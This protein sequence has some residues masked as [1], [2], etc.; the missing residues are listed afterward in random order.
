M[1][2]APFRVFKSWESDRS[3]ARNHEPGGILCPNPGSSPPLTYS[4]RSIGVYQSKK[5]KSSRARVAQSED[6]SAFL[7]CRKNERSF[8]LHSDQ[9][10]IRPQSGK[11]V[12]TPLV[13]RAMRPRRERLKNLERA[14]TASMKSAAKRA[15][16]IPV[17]NDDWELLPCKRGIAGIPHGFRFEAEEAPQT[18]IHSVLE[19]IAALCGNMAV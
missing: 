11:E 15:P 12:L 4:Q 6:Y 2:G 19:P 3:H 16:H 13:G 8:L 14:R 10:T 5:D 17:A 1:Q 9:P 7:S 18:F